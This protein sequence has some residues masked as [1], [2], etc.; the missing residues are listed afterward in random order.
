MGFLIFK[1]AWEIPQFRFSLDFLTS[2]GFQ[3]TLENSSI[4]YR[5]SI[6][7]IIGLGSPGLSLPLSSS[8]WAAHRTL[9]Y[10]IGCHSSLYLSKVVLLEFLETLFF[11]AKVKDALYLFYD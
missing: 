1:S 4:T 2:L 8:F 7:Y 11:R 3:V 10:Q 6:S 5:F 9:S